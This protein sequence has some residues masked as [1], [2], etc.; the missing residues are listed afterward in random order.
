MYLYL[1]LSS[2]TEIQPN[3]DIFF[4]LFNKGVHLFDLIHKIGI[5][6]SGV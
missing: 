5:V 2:L 4:Y 1:T 6:L 3:P